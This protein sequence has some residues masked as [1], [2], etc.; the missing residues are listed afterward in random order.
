MLGFS[1]SWCYVRFIAG[2]FGWAAVALLLLLGLFALVSSCFA[3]VGFG[4]CFWVLVIL[5]CGLGVGLALRVFGFVDGGYC[6]AWMVW[7]T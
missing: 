1:L 7:A 3:D 2:L 4:D 5:G 6:F